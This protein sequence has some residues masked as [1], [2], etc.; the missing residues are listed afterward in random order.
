[1]S[2]TGESSS[3]STSVAPSE[4]VP[5]PPVGAPRTSMPTTPLTLASQV[6]QPL[7]S[8]NLAGTSGGVVT[9]IPSVPFVP[10]SFTHTT[11]SGPIG[12]RHLSKYFLG[13]GGTFPH[14]LH[15]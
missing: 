9:G 10:T 5:A 6:V 15:M 1:M 14:P 4:G 13:M 2:T 7:A 3:T 8:K 12:P 11:Q